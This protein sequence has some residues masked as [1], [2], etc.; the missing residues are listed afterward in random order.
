VCYLPSVDTAIVEIAAGDTMHFYYYFY[1]TPG[2]ATGYTR[3]GLRN[4]SDFSN[5]YMR[6]LWAISSDANAIME[7]AHDEPW[8]M[9]PNPAEGPVRIAGLVPG[10]S[11]VWRDASGRQVLRSTGSEVATSGLAP[12]VYLAQP[13]V[14]GAA[15]GAPQR[16]VIR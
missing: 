12:G 15:Y 1:T 11:V 2:A 13:M 5:N 9:F 4:E 3:V 6:D 8:S 14:D 10:A 16:L 7:A